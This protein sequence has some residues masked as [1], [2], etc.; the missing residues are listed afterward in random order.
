MRFKNKI[1]NN[2]KMNRKMESKKQNRMMI[3]KIMKIRRMVK[4]KK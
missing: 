1:K 4:S 3:I 2:K